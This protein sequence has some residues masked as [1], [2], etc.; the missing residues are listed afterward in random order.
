MAIARHE[1]IK[2][3]QPLIYEDFVFRRLLDSQSI[4]EWQLGYSASLGSVEHSVRDK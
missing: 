2:I 1:Q 3:L 4:V